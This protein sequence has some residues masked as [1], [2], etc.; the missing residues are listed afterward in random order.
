[1]RFAAINAGGLRRRL[2]PIREGRLLPIREGR[3]L[4]IREGRLLPIREGRL[5]PIREGR[6]LPIREGRLLP[7]REGRLL[8]IQEGHL[9]PIRGGHLLPIREGRLLPIRPDRVQRRD[10]VQC[11]DQCQVR[12]GL[13]AT[14]LGSGL[15]TG[16]TQPA[17]H[18]SYRG[19]H[20][21]PHALRRPSAGSVTHRARHSLSRIADR[22]RHAAHRLRSTN[23][24]LRRGRK[25]RPLSRARLASRPAP[26]GLPPEHAARRVQHSRR[27]VAGHQFSSPRDLVPATRVA[28][29]RRGSTRL[30]TITPSVR[31]SPKTATWVP[32]RR[33]LSL[34]ADITLWPRTVISPVL[35][36]SMGPPTSLTSS[37]RRVV[38]VPLAWRSARMRATCP[39]RRALA[40]VT[41]PSISTGTF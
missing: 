4:P 33:Q 29:S 31:R 12:A 14:L 8:P 2:L 41:A 5:L 7:I 22:S 13:A 15:R 18:R 28:L 30:A 34:P 24:W 1:M 17:D 39:I 20:P 19:S 26:P 36:L 3:L 16:Q 9:L 21:R 23:G 27:Q 25:N 40:D 10:R 35:T 6:L 38:S 32:G 37:M 11:R